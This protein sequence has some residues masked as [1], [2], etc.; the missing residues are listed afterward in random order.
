MQGIEYTQVADFRILAPRNR[1]EIST[2]REGRESAPHVFVE[3]VDRALPGE[4]G[5][6]FVVSFRRRVAIEAVHGAR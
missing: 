6:G 4:I 2:R 1:E 5:R 3:P